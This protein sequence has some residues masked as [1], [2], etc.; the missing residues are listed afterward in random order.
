MTSKFPSF[1]RALDAAAVMLG[2]R[3]MEFSRALYA[4][5]WLDNEGFEETLPDCF[6]MPTDGAPNFAVSQTIMVI[7]L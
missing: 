1:R 5:E 7:K 3:E 2:Y 6:V 4:W